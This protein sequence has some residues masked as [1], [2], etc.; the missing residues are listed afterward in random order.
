MTQSQVQLLVVE[1]IGSSGNNDRRFVV[2]EGSNDLLSFSVHFVLEAPLS[3]I[4][5]LKRFPHLSQAEPE[6]LAYLFVEFHAQDIGLI[7]KVN[8][9]IYDVILIKAQCRLQHILVALNHG[10]VKVV[11]LLVFRGKIDYVWEKEISGF[12]QEIYDMPVRDLDWIA[13]LG[14][15]RF[16][17]QF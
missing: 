10:A 11:F 13:G 14:C 3:V 7:V 16:D 9:W 6:G 2:L 1:I 17:A 8:R 5:S 15:H 12:S 4:G